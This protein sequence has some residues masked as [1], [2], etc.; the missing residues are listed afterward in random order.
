MKIC[1]KVFVLFFEMLCSDWWLEISM[2]VAGC[3]KSPSQ[4]SII[5]L[6]SVIPNSI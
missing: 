2:V 1:C 4:T 6:I 3:V 5:V